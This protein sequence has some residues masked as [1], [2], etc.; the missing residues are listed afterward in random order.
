MRWYQQNHRDLPW[1][2]TKDPYLIWLSEVMLQQT[3]VQQGLAYYIHFSET[4]P[5]VVD[6]AA[7]P[8]E[9][10]LRMWQ[11]LGYY[12]RARNLHKAAKE[13]VS[14][15]NAVFPTAYKDLLS[16]PGVGEYTAA[17]VSSFSSG[18]PHAVLDG[19]VY[20]VL[21]RYLGVKEPIQTSRSKKTFQKLANELL[22]EQQAATYNQAIM[23]FG[24]LQCKPV[25]P[26]CA[27]CPLQVNCYAFQQNSIDQLPVKTKRQKSKLRYF[28]YF[29][30]QDKD[31]VIVKKRPAGDIWQHLYDFP[32]IE[33]DKP[34]STDKLLALPDFQHYFGKNA[35]LIHTSKEYKHILSH[36]D[37]YVRFIA[38]ENAEINLTQNS[39]WNYVLIKDLDK[40]AKSKLIVSFINDFFS[41]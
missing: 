20:R 30:V 27:A 2:K 21:A 39:S 19:N 9:Q 14:R 5:T 36:Q 22:D 40:L 35:T 8:E 29:L 1:R 25:N 24:A 18:A 6:L 15:F 4:F 41:L 10:V 7:A 28:Y 11:G 23:E 37:L 12:S 26:N 38:I 17:A 32:M 31:Q 33:V 34:L 13:V 3:R 16:L